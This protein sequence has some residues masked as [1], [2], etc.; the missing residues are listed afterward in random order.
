M[1]LFLEKY[2][3]VAGSVVI[4]IVTITK[5]IAKLQKIHQTPRDPAH[6]AKQCSCI[7]LS[8]AATWKVGVPSVSTSR[9]LGQVANP[10]QGTWTLAKHLPE[11]EQ[12]LR[13]SLTNSFHCHT[14]R[15]C[16]IKSLTTLLPPPQLRAETKNL[17]H[18]RSWPRLATFPTS[19]NMSISNT[20]QQRPNFRAFWAVRCK[21]TNVFLW[22]GFP[23]SNKVAAV[24][25]ALSPWVQSCKQ[26]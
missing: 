25:Q 20:T 17:P 5:I 21:F 9:K 11:A 2:T 16:N 13:H 4:W 7:R 26:S 15:E 12:M 24:G 1:S 19:G 3:M 8:S 23:I 22:C 18:A 6:S 10:P 14:Q